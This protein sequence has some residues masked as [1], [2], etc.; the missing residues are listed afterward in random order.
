MK[1]MN[2]EY[3]SMCCL[4]QLSEH[5]VNIHFSLKTLNLKSQF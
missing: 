3:T 1:I 5:C 4:G 2:P